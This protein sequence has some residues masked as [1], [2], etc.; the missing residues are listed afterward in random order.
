MGRA[1]SSGGG[2]G[3]SSFGIGYFAIDYVKR[4]DSNNYGGD[5]NSTHNSATN[6]SK[7]TIKS[8]KNMQ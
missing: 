7:P 6:Y 1:L 8:I 2:A 5:G 4:S 3:E